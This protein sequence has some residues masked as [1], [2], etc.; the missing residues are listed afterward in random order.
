MRFWLEEHNSM[1]RSTAVRYT[2]HA[3]A[4]RSN[5]LSTCGDILAALAGIGASVMVQFIGDLPMAELIVL[6]VGMPMLIVYRKRALRRDLLWVYALMAF[7]LFNQI[8]TDIYR[9]TPRYDWMRGNAAIVFFA[10]DLAFISMLLEKNTRRKILFFVGLIFTTLLQARFA[11]SDL[12]QQNMWKFGYSGGVN[13]GIVLISCYFYNRRQYLVTLALLLAICGVNLL[14]NF[15]SPVLLLMLMIAMVVPVIPEQIG[16]WRVL[17]PEGTRMRFVVLITLAIVATSL[18]GVAVTWASTKGWLGEE[19]QRKNEAQANVQ[20]GLLIGGRPEILV[21]SIAVKDSP[22][23]GHGS[24]AKDFKY[25]EILSDILEERGM[26]S[27]DV[28]SQEEDSEGVIPAHS[29]LMSAWV[30]AGIMGAVFWVYVFWIMVKSV[31]Y[32]GIKRPPFAPLLAFLQIEMMWDILFSPFGSS[33]RI[34]ESVVLIMALDLLPR[35]DPAFS[36]TSRVW[37]RGALLHNLSTQQVLSSADEQS[38]L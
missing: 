17:P 26:E 16:P 21:S 19:A 20:G 25:L 34:V 12:A 14:L 31:A 9:I 7:W 28:D 27:G 1:S 30:W 10:M 33:R 3:P 2:V 24:W 38:E 8:L 35:A 18:A 15:R 13:L 37:R 5:V 29:H 23:L 11:P 22:I 4:M 36:P 6:F 32:L